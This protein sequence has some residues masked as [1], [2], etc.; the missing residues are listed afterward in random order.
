VVVL[1]TLAAERLFGD[2]DPL[3]KTISINRV[4]FQVIGVYKDNASF[5]AGGLRTKGVMPV[6]TLQR[7]LNVRRGD[8][9]LV[10]KPR[11]DV[12]RDIAMD[13]VTAT[14]RGLRGLRPSEE[15]DF[16]LIT[17]E[18]L[19]ETYD[20]IFGMFFL[21]MIALSAV[22][23]IVGGVGVVAIMMISVT[24]R[25]REIGVRKAL[26]ATP[27]SIVR[28][29]VQEAMVLTLLAGYLGL[30][31]GVGV[32]EAISRYLATLEGAPLSAPEVDLNAALVAVGVLAVAG[33][34]AS[35]VPARHA[36]GVAPVE[37]LRAE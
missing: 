11:A 5:L 19:F 17:Q 12:S 20:R 16:A 25:T 26:G 13:D 23:L 8:M 36:A 7:A 6:T 4:Q 34:V 21:V 37:A 10:V 1:N 24:E 35:I 28:L 9:G 18:K 31:A 29:I 15:S 14:L 3:F 2:S 30:V 32:L 27:G 33:A 22:G